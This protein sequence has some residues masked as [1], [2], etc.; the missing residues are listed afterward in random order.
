M[1]T[2]EKI[3]DKATFIVFKT[4]EWVLIFALIYAF[5]MLIKNI[6]GEIT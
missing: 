2:F 3:I 6:V 1:R 5:V 4:I